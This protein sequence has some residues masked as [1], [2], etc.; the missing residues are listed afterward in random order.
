M[1]Q[2]YT[3]AEVGKLDSA[4][5]NIVLDEVMRSAVDGGMGSQRCEMMAET[6]GSLASIS[7]R[8]RILAKLRKVSTR[9]Q[10][11]AR[12]ADAAVDFGKDINETK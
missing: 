2:K 7:A 8:G 5:V 12:Y 10:F 9:D 4:V 3:W 11:V 1:M 6:L